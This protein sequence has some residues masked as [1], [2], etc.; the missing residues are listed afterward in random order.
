M[1]AHG[2]YKEG[3]PVPEFKNK[4]MKVHPSHA[5]EIKDVMEGD[6]GRYTLVLRN[7]AAGLQESL[8]ITLVVNGNPAP[9][10][11]RSHTHTHT[12]TEKQ[13]HTQRHKQRHA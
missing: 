13:R 8:N 3:R 4:R 9:R 7:T 6:G 12:R 2:R 1:H 5:L 11:Q 10:S